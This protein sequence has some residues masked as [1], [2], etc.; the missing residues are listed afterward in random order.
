MEKNKISVYYASKLRGFIRHIVENP[1]KGIEYEYSKDSFYETSSKT[2]LILKKIF[3]GILGDILGLILKLNVKDSECDIVQTY[4]RFIKSDKKYVILLENPTAI[5]HYSLNRSKT[6]LGSRN[7]KKELNR[8]YLKSIVCISKA[9]YSTLESLIPEIPSNIIIE[10][11]YPYIPNNDD[12]NEKVINERSNLESLKCL[13]ISSEF[14]LKSGCEIIDVFEKLNNKNINNNIQLTIVTKKESIPS[15]YLIKI[16]QLS[17]V[18]LLEFNLSYEQLKE[19]YTTHMILLHPTRQDS[20]PLVVL[21][22]IKSGMVVLAADLYA[23]PEMV[24]DDY[25]GY[26]VKAKYR[27]FNEDNMPNPQVW[28]NRL[29]TIYSNYIDENIVAF[30]YD[31]LTYLYKNRSKLNEMSLNSYELATNGEFSEEYIKLKWRNLY[32]QVLDR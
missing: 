31:K 8:G 3:G 11:I 30:I 7:I 5:Y 13:F 24:K 6:L 12:I 25:N 9:C 27:F 29:K 17:N 28:N 2:K 1:P 26:L 23:I 32:E 19:L 22:A 20:S 16:E 21:E 10:Q 15:E 14:K 4:N 18:N